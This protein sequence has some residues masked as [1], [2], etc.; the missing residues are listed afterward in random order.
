MLGK[1]NNSL[2]A[3]SNRFYHAKDSY[4]KI[5]YGNGYFRHFDSDNKTYYVKNHRSKNL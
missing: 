4:S 2:H 1:E 3:T 5:K